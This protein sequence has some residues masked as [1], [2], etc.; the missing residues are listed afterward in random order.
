VAVLNVLVDRGPR[1]VWDVLSDGQAYAEWVMG[2]RHIRDVDP[3]WPGLGSKI[4]YVMGIGP[5]TFED[6]TTV[7][8][9]EPGQ[10]LE[11]EAHAGP[12]G[13][14]RIS[15]VLL[16]WGEDRTV[17]ILD[18]HPLSGPG[19]RWHSVLVEGL[20]RLRNERMLRSLAR[21]VSK[22]H[23]RLPYTEPPADSGMRSAC[24]A[25]PAISREPGPCSFA[26]GR[27]PERTA[28]ERDEQRVQQVRPH[29]LPHRVRLLPGG[30]V[31]SAQ[32]V[33]RGQP[34]A[35]AARAVR[36]LRQTVSA[37]RG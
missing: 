7:R 34:A 35:P 25:L 11:L 13:T 28:G 3:A 20:L 14:A 37:T 12:L 31:A 9:I 10:H 33:Q 30:A 2:T 6:I 1:E 5:W 36:R 22:R 17:V 18:E 27:I 8:L 15:I 32:R 16:P 26:A 29:L 23:S 21:V 19:A 4:R 24:M